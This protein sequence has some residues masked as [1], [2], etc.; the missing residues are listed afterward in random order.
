[1]IQK[2]WKIF[3]QKN[4]KVTKREHPFMRFISTY[5]LEILN[6]FSPELQH[7]DT[8]SVINSKL[9]NLLTQLRG[10][11]FVTILVLVFKNIES[12]D[13]TKHD[14]FY[15]S[16]KAEIIINENDVDDVLQSI[17]TP[18]ITKIQKSL[19]KDSSWIIDSVI[20]HTISVSKYNPLAEA[21]LSYFQEN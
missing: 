2:K 8:G 17:Y 3:K 13:K 4:V 9:L 18:I 7:K 10:L 19:G 14:N 15:S 20:D 12:E 6:S 16:W 5:N 21:V 11:R 1:M